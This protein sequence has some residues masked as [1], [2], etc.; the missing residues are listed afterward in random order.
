MSELKTDTVFPFQIG[1]TPTY[2]TKNISNSHGLSHD[3]LRVED[4]FRKIIK[5][6]GHYAV[7]GHSRS[8]ILVPMEST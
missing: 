4:E 5:N 1:L 3:F 2:V 8:P 6:N 7:H